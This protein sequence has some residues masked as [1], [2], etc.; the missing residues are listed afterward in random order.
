MTATSSSRSDA[1]RAIATR[2]LTA[3]DVPAMSRN[4]VPTSS[5]FGIN[6]FGARQ[7]RDK[8][9]KDIYAKL[10]ASIRQGKKL[11]VDIDIPAATLELLLKR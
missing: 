4:P 7:M 3:P 5:Y 8:L 6:T 2:V 9:P 1:L 11:D 10:V